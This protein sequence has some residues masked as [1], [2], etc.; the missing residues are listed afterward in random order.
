MLSTLAM[1]TPSGASWAAESGAE[2]SRPAWLGVWL[3]DA[4]TGVRV[5]HVVRGSPADR[6]GLRE[7]DRLAFMDGAQV[8]DA[9]QVSRTIATHLPRERTSLTVVRGTQTFV[10]AV[11]LAENPGA[12]NIIRMEHLGAPAPAWSGAQPLGAAPSSLSQLRG[13]VVLLDFWAVWCG[14]CRI[15]APRL[16]AL[17][18]KF[19]PQGLRVVGMTT[20]DAEAAAVY[21]GRTGLRYPV[22]LDPGAL[23]TRAY[24]VTGL[25]TLFVIDRRGVVRDVGVGF[26][27]SRDAPLEALIQKLL[28]EPAP[29]D[30]EGVPVGRRDAGSSLR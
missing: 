20:D 17:Q 21:A 11:V 14:P 16:G 4:L 25:P 22:V 19:G 9:A 7:G 18:S 12:E 13:Q 29:V 1:M 8:K 15:V 10:L 30:G 6:A 2:T 23:V 27:P 26:D 3:D 5:S 24:H 28:A